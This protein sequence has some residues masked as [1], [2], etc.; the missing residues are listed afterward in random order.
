MTFYPH[1]DESRLFIFIAYVTKFIETNPQL[2]LKQNFQT[3]N[4]KMLQS[5]LYLALELALLPLDGN[6]RYL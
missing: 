1:D 6:T 5:R 2:A 3:R 4:L